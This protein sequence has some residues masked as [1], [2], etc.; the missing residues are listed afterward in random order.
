MD[1][2]ITPAAENKKRLPFLGGLWAFAS[3]HAAA[4]EFL[5]VF[6]AFFGRFL[7]Y[8]WKYFYTL[9][10]YIN[11]YGNAA[12]YKSD[13]SSLWEFLGD[14]GA[15]A[16][17][18]A[19]GITDVFLWS[20]FFG[21]MIFAV[22]ILALMYSAFAVIMRRIF[23]RTFG[24]GYM[25][26]AILC[27]SPL[28][29]DG[30]YR[31]SEAA[32][33]IPALFFA[34]LSAWFIFCVRERENTLY[35]P[36]FAAAQL[37]CF[38]FHDQVAV[39]S[40]ALCAFV[41]LIKRDK[42]SMAGLMIIANFCLY[43]LYRLIGGLVWTGR[44]E[45]A[46]ML[47]FEAEYTSR[48]LI[49][50]LVSVGEAAGAFLP[51][52]FI[53]AF[54]R[55]IETVAADRAVL[56]ILFAAAITALA[57]AFARRRATPGQPQ[58]RSALALL[59]GAV[60][61]LAPLLVFFIKKD[62]TVGIS[63]IVP[64]L[65]GAALIID[66]LCRSVTFKSRFAEGILIALTVFFSLIASVSEISDY[67]ATMEFDRK[68]A[69]SVIALAEDS[70]APDEVNAGTRIAIINMADSPGT[71]QNYSCGTHIS[72]AVGDT[73]C[74]T[75]LLRAVSGNGEFPCVT[76]MSVDEDGYFYYGGDSDEFRIENFDVLFV[77][78]DYAMIHV[79]PAR[80]FTESDY[81][82][83]A[84]YENYLLYTV[85]FTRLAHVSEFATYGIFKFY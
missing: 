56:Y 51:N 24:T 22:M 2:S 36:L 55:G 69:D 76:V 72:S 79:I 59:W 4:V 23:E 62:S 28:A 5:A 46:V 61:M 52:V 3:K 44:G 57:F 40:M 58:K 85:D 75:G 60:F 78:T 16:H 83:R 34:A 35:I 68:A 12:F 84:K 29:F 19:S 67:R 1:A 54:R 41:A 39:L 65:C 18:P 7:Y 47:P 48:V 13:Y 37:V 27:L 53:R 45:S 14:T 73:R 17:N 63:G 9:D 77:A 74:F 15:L 20:H 32:H 6:A 70:F 33:V 11:Y 66:T 64:C 80:G 25:F 8:G 26:S 42:Y 31:F 49:P 71:E 82:P 30:L 43:E 21:H 10:D 50:S 38:A 81:D